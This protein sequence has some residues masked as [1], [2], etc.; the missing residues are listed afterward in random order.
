MFII[1][2]YYT[3]NTPYQQVVHDYLMNSLNKLNLKSDIRGI[4]DLGDWQRNT[5]YKPIFIKRM[6]EKYPET[7][8]VFVDADAEVMSYPKLFDEIPEEYDVAVHILDR[9][10]WYNRKFGE[11]E[12]KE[13]LSGTLL[14]KNNPRSHALVEKWIRAC[15][16]RPFEWEQVIL[17]RVLVENGTKVYE[18]PLSYCYIKSM[19]NGEA[20]YVKCDEAVIVHNQ[21]SRRLKK[22][23]KW[24]LQ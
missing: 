9:D 11:D 24:G 18:L 6:L 23:A 14:V 15:L 17:Q 8:I 19:P 20:P 13:L 7:D 2:S 1:T 3:I 21:V 16:N 5:S 12:N 4:E 22:A 10:C